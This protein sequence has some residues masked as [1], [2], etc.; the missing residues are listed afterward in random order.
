M[1]KSISVCN[2]MGEKILA[3]IEGE[4]F[5]IASINSHGGFDMPATQAFMGGTVSKQAVAGTAEKVH[6]TKELPAWASVRAPSSPDYIVIVVGA[7]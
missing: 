7:P 6:T 5:H 1:Q 2:F 3:R 4:R